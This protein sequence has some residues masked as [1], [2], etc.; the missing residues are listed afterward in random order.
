MQPRTPKVKGL[1]KKLKLK[2]IAIISHRGIKT[3]QSSL[4]YTVKVNGREGRQSTRTRN[5]LPS[6]HVYL[7]YTTYGLLNRTS[8][9]CVPSSCTL[10]CCTRVKD[11]VDSVLDCRVETAVE[12]QPRDGR[13]KNLIVKNIS[14]LNTEIK[15]IEAQ[16]YSKNGD[17]KHLYCPPKPK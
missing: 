8:Q 4:L 1:H 2:R 6:R 5:T 11:R 7:A 3:P 13:V 10:P 16:W 15:R 12:T 17:V 9:Q 14:I